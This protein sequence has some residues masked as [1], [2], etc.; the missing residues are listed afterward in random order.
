MINKLDRRPRGSRQQS[1]RQAFPIPVFGNGGRKSSVRISHFTWIPFPSDFLWYQ[2][3]S[4]KSQV[5]GQSSDHLS[6]DFSSTAVNWTPSNTSKDRRSL[7]STSLRKMENSGLSLH[8]LLLFG[9]FLL[10]CSHCLRRNCRERKR[11]EKGKTKKIWASVHSHSTTIR[12]KQFRVFIYFPYR[13][14][15][16]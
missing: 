5:P 3:P 14:R 11:K 9:S 8:S 15:R 6:G 10:S 1:D 4:R 16:N 7:V 12:F 2:V 13:Y